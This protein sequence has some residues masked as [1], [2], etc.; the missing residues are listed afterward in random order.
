MNFDIMP[1]TGR[2]RGDCAQAQGF[3]VRR[4]SRRKSSCS[5]LYALFETVRPNEVDP[6]ARLADVVARIAN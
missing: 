1:D 2:M 4:P 6:E 5:D 3:S